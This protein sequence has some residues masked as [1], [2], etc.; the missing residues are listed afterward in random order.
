M[1]IKKFSGK[2]SEH[3]R[4]NL[5]HLPKQYL[6]SKP[7]KKVVKT[8]KSRG[9]QGAWGGKDG[10][11]VR[12]ER[13]EWLERLERLG[14]NGTQR[15]PITGGRW[16]ESLALSFWLLTKLLALGLALSFGF[17]LSLRP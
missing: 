4:V 3:F 13:F 6:A 17:G 14:L 5:K 15:P 11:L 1:G 9:P 10:G 8:D 16:V 7:T 12:L 2:S